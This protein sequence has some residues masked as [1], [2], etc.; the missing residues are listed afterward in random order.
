MNVYKRWLALSQEERANIHI[1]K[2]TLNHLS[3][4]IVYRRINPLDDLSW[5]TRPKYTNEHLD[6]GKKY[7]SM[8]EVNYFINK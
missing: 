1:S 6:A 8:V 7:V 5:W 4:L 2:L 3:N